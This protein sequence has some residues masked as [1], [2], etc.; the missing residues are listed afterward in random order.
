MPYGIAFEFLDVGMG[1]GTLVQMPPWDR[2]P[3]VLVDFGEKGTKSKTPYID[4]IKFLVKRISLICRN[5][6]LPHPIIDHLFIT[7][8]DLDHWNRLGNLIE[9]VAG[10]DTN[11]WH[12]LGKWGDKEKL[13]IN[14]L[15]FGGSWKSDYENK[16]DDVTIAIIGAM[17][18][19]PD[20]VH[21]GNKDRDYCNFPR[22]SYGQPG[23]MANIYL[24]SSN[25]P[26]KKGS[27]INDR[28]LVLMFEY[29]KHKVILTGDAGSEVEDKIVD[30]YK[31]D[32]DF[33]KSFGLKLGHHG[34]QG[35]TCDKWVN[36]VR[37]RA[38]FASGDI[39]W[40]HP[41]CT[42][43]KQ[44]KSNDLMDLKENHWF[45]C[46]CSGADNDY[47][48]ISTNRAICTN[49]WYIVTNPKGET[50]NGY[51][52][53]QHLENCGL[54]TGVQWRLQIDEGIDPVFIHT[55]QWPVHDDKK[56]TPSFCP[57]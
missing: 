31:G 12:T 16:L 54:Y 26:E 36:A 47:R 52:G 3:I 44:V 23:N 55:D 43:I 32:P 27:N 35:S 13:G 51:D 21:L 18:Y 5:R 50:R 46:S 1:D 29:N 38:I 39:K 48:S 2:G 6:G 40:G 9:G 28:S 33:L 37:P 41:Y 8:G 42:A 15:T 4:A 17:P 25:Y 22:W 49:L 56:I 10:N 30:F 45:A 34:S 57:P 14:R 53:K 11:L 19:P 7:H 20:I 24:L